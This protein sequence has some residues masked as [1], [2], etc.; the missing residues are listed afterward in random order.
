M[1]LKAAGS[2]PGGDS[3]PASFRTSPTAGGARGDVF[4]KGSP[5]F[6]EAIAREKS[7]QTLKRE[8]GGA[9][10]S[11]NCAAAPET[12]PGK[13]PWGVSLEDTIASADYMSIVKYAG[14][15]RWKPEQIQ[16]I[17]RELSESLETLKATEG[18]LKRSD[19]TFEGQSGLLRAARTQLE[20]RQLQA[21]HRMGTL[22]A[23]DRDKKL[24][25]LLR[26]EKGMD[27]KAIRSLLRL[28]LDSPTDRFTFGIDAKAGVAAEVPFFGRAE[29]F[30]KGRATFEAEV[31]SAGQYLVSVDGRLSGGG[32]VSSDTLGAG[33][34]AEAGAYAKITYIFPNE[35]DAACYIQSIMHQLKLSKAPPEYHPPIPKHHHGNYLELKAHMGPVKFTGKRQHEESK[36]GFPLPW[37]PR[38]HRRFVKTK[39]IR[40]E[41]V[42]NL[43]LPMG[44]MLV[45]MRAD[46]TVESGNQASNGTAL[47]L[48]FKLGKDISG[49]E[50]VKEALAGSLLEFITRTKPEVI[51]AI[52]GADKMTAHELKE[53]A[54]Q[55]LTEVV[56]RGTVSGSVGL[57]GILDVRVQSSR[58]FFQ[59]ENST[60][61]GVLTDFFSHCMNGYASADTWQFS[62]AYAA[63]EISL[64]GDVRFRSGIGGHFFAELG[65]HFENRDA[66]T[67]SGS[68][69]HARAMLYNNLPGTRYS[70]MQL[71]E[72]KKD[73][74]FSPAGNFDRDTFVV[75]LGKIRNDLRLLYDRPEWRSTRAMGMPADEYMTNVETFLEE[76]T[77]SMWEGLTRDGSC[78]E[79]FDDFQKG[80]SPARIREVDQFIGYQGL[81]NVPLEEVVDQYK[82]LSAGK[83]MI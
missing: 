28:A 82:L 67:T 73:G 40:E 32:G 22:S 70:G 34:G 65:L 64:D 60:I 72:L 55:K 76:V 26:F 16:P 38:N 69:L 12:M 11:R 59:G 58:N 33:A 27:H 35:D 30:V 42:G 83:L 10:D 5:E 51:N 81:E 14:L 45:R 41:V 29:L 31:D 56:A 18:F 25:E 4:E 74:L 46:D 49:H 44:K 50:T 78:T 52:P 37:L 13:I 63:R 75:L 62:R 3:F 57:T 36:A 54:L 9:G 20:V 39:M 71:K 48:E 6:S 19:G 23:D 79:S 43:D 77:R 21:A 61:F 2:T 80:V 68:L 47:R 8:L 17:T 66:V 1:E 24:A 53:R 15:S 7:L